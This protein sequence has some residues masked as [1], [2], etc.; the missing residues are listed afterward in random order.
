MT[1]GIGTAGTSSL[2]GGLD[3][4]AMEVNAEVPLKAFLFVGAEETPA[5]TFSFPFG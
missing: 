5:S 3:A 4:G 1:L 2:R